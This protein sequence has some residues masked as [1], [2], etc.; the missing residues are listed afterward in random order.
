MKK[1]NLDLI[2]TEPYNDGDFSISVDALGEYDICFRDGDNGWRW[3]CTVDD[4][5]TALNV[6]DEL[7][8]SSDGFYTLP[9]T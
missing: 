6:I 3:F 8:K 1:E 7:K 2:F 4:Y 5:K 9:I